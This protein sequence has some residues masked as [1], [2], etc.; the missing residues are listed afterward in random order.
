MQRDSR[1]VV[2]KGRGKKEMVTRC[3]MGTEF[4][5][6]KMKSIPEMDGGDSYTAV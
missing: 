5:F 3:L 4:L 2:A 6:Y 1:M